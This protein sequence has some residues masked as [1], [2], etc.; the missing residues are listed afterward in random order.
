MWAC[1]RLSDLLY[2][3]IYTQTTPLVPLFSTK[4]L[5]D[6]PIRA[7]RFR[8]R[9]MHYSYTISHIPGKQLT[10]ADTLSRAPTKGSL[11]SGRISCSCNRFYPPS[12]RTAVGSYSTMPTRKQSI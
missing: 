2:H 4:K 10:I 6:L 5:E 12:F 8:L 3:S 7:L 9:M 11:E 1:E